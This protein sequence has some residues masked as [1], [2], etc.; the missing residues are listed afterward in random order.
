MNFVV[1]VLSSMVAGAI[2]LLLVGI[3][4][5]KAR[6]TLTAILGR[7]LGIDIEYVYE[8]A[9]DASDD[10][11]AELKRARF[12]QLLTGRGGE[13]QR[14]TFACLLGERT[15]SRNCPFTILL[16]QVEV[17]SGN[18]DWTEVRE[19][20][21]AQ[22]DRSFGA[23]VLKVQLRT[24]VEFLRPHLRVGKVELRLFNCPHIGRILITDRSVFFTPYSASAHAR[25]CRVFQYRSGGDTYQTL[26]RL[27]NQLWLYGEEITDVHS[28]SL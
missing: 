22:I 26:A 14:D 21:L 10:I 15:E 9:R 20:E 17:P 27:F 25:D 6:W 12:V 7:I 3:V 19:H 2:M 8:N 11:R 13:L 16:P 28:A 23:G 4:S 1:N 24:T 5:R 18:V